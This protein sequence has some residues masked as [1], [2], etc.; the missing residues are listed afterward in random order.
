V[1]VA[2]LTHD[3]RE[4]AL[5]HSIQLSFRDA[6]GQRR[7]P[8]P[9]AIV[10]TL[11]VLG[12]PVETDRDVANALRARREEICSRGTDP[13]A[14]WWEGAP[15][16]IAVIGTDGRE[17]DLRF[18]LTLEDGGELVLQPRHIERIRLVSDSCAAQF[19][20]WRVHFAPESVPRG[21]HRLRV[22]GLANADERDMLILR[23]PARAFVASKRRSWGV[24]APVYGLRSARGWGAGDF[25]D[26]ASLI[27]VISG[28]GGGGVATLPLLATFLDQPFEPSP[29][30]P[31]SRLFWNEF[32]LDPARIPEFRASE[33]A[34]ARMEEAAGACRDLRSADL[35][36]YA[37]V[38][39]LKRDVLEILAE[40]FF[41]NGSAERREAFARFL[42]EKPR[43]ESYARFRAAVEKGR[44]PGDAP[45]D[46]LIDLREDEEKGRRYHLFAQWQCERQL[47]GV[48]AL[49]RSSGFGLYLD[50]PLGVHGG[51]Y[52]AWAER[53]LFVRDA[54]TGAPPDP[55][56]TG[57]Q[58]WGAPP[59]HP[60]NLRR[61]GYRYVIES[62]RAIMRYAGVLRFD[63]VMALHR[64][65]W[66]PNGMPPDEGVYVRYATE[67]NFAILAI[68]SHR[69]R[70]TVV[71]E[72]LGTVPEIV[73]ARMKRHAVRSMY[74]LQ[75]EIGPGNTPRTP[76]ADSVASLNTHDMPPFEGFLTGDD[77]HERA[78]HGHVDDVAAQTA[79]RE[80][81][82]ETLNRF[83]RERGLVPEDGPAPLFEGATRFL[84]NSGAELVLVNLEDLWKT[85]DAQ[86]LPGT[87]MEHPNWRRK[88]ARTIEDLSNDS[89]LA[90]RLGSIDAWRKQGGTR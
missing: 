66:I 9:E 29:Y 46:G 14:V 28:A 51:G 47:E 19:A 78:E 1:I 16:T 85:T 17:R 37:R 68:E 42:D 79:E 59:M 39:R 70:T 13:V 24:F 55:F 34:R 50:V 84:A 81:T 43:A 63:H 52:D 64:L 75:Y 90:G 41:A 54:A 22:T 3:L 56:F 89:E 8:S 80:Q 74:V 18:R 21:Y 35:V 53:A 26:L 69:H 15:L 44:W 60:D 67:E 25:T 71:G 23:A 82:K 73:R 4:L 61:S 10:A 40:E 58:N 48:A 2:R 76:P 6:M 72:D 49:A 5:L 20:R 77:I 87:H 62:L 7:R 57:G 33:A 88:L 45:P 31:V 12:A 86:N 38:M 36:D 65:Y 83:L 27:R 32:Y 30:S 11:R